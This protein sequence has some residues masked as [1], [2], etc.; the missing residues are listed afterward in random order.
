MK[1][2]TVKISRKN[3]YSK[4]KKILCGKIGKNLIARATVMVLS[5]GL[6]FAIY[7]GTVSVSTFSRS[8]PAIN[9]IADS[10]K[11]GGS[12]EFFGK[13]GKSMRFKLSDLEDKLGLGKGE[14]KGIAFTALP[15]S[16]TGT[17]KL[18]GKDVYLYK[19]ISRK[20]I[21]KLEF[22]PKKNVIRTE[23]KFL[24]YADNSVTT[25]AII[26]LTPGRE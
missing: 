1:K 15:Y 25:T 14:L 12:I 22:I 2:I 19:K 17:V 20:E 21:D 18:D 11:A 6:C 10:P 16:S 13:M 7:K 3:K 5:L 26:N 9:K 4:I 23:I 8:K 24:P